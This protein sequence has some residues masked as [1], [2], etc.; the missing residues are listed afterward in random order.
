MVQ[1]IL[2]PAGD[3]PMPARGAFPALAVFWG[4]GAMAH[5]CADAI[6]AVWLGKCATGNPPASAREQGADSVWVISRFLA[7]RCPCPQ[8][9]SR[10][11]VIPPAGAQFRTDSYSCGRTATMVAGRLL[12][13]RRPRRNPTHPPPPCAAFGDAF[14]ADLD[15]RIG[16]GGLF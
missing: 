6:S 1:S 3:M 14:A 8:R 13:R 5:S 15:A 2:L 16:R 12:V 9:S 11:R 4:D 7:R 10:I